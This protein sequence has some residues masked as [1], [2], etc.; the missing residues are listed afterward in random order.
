MKSAI[1]RKNLK[2]RDRKEEE[3]Y[4]FTI[5]SKT[6]KTNVVKLE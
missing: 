3:N 4:I 2:I 5:I 1:K 6:L